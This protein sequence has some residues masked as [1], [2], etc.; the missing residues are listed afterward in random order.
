MA[1][2]TVDTNSGMKCKGCG[3]PIS[4]SCPSLHYCATCLKPSAKDTQAT[5]AN[6]PQESD[7]IHEA[8]VNGS[9]E[10]TEATIGDTFPDSFADKMREVARNSQDGVIRR[11]LFDGATL[12]DESRV[13]IDLLQAQNEHILRICHSV[14]SG[15]HPDNDWEVG[16][17]Y[18]GKEI[19]RVIRGEIANAK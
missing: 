6:T 19:E 3:G 9:L 16:R 10:R 11:A 17:S 1:D 5:F 7:L 14:Q 8:D 15:V 2:G 13:E 18:L 12:L 4:W